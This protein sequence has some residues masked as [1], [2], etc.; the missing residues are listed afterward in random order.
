MPLHLVKEGESKMLWLRSQDNPKVQRLVQHTLGLFCPIYAARLQNG[1]ARLTGRRAA[2]KNIHQ[3][4][5]I[6]MTSRVDDGA[7]AFK[8]QSISFT[9][10]LYIE[11][12]RTIEME[13]KSGDA[14]VM[15][16][17]DPS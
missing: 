3:T 10:P 17:G 12:T 7:L 14:V 15:A 16:S 5:F 9:L 6:A 8:N 13:T 2:H 4:T 1:E 11:E